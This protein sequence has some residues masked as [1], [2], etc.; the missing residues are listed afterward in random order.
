MF[1]YFTNSLIIISLNFNLFITIKD[2]RLGNQRKGY[3]QLIY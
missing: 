3:I 1:F 2:T